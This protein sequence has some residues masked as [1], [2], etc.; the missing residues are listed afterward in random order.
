M[1]M[2]TERVAVILAAG[3]ST[4]LGG[5]PKALLEV[6][7]EPAV[8]RIAR[9]CRE[10]GFEPRVVV[11]LHAAMIRGAFSLPVPDVVEN[12]DWARGRTGSIQ[13]GL[14]GLG[15]E[16]EVLLW[17]VDHPFVQAKTLRRLGTAAEHDAMG[18]WFIPSFGGFGGHPVLLEP[19]VISRIRDL[20][21]GTPLRDLLPE[22]GP[23]VVRVPVDDVGVRANVD[24]EEDFRRYQSLVASG[25]DAT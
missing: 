18:V 1:T 19:P 24:T 8:V 23:Q 15:P 11:G 2:P 3:A 17:P 12:P 13:K 4:R 14:E 21:P 16:T 22:F 10:E 7:G 5:R 6:S 20:S 9:I 25:G